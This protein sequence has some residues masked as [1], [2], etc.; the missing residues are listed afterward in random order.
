MGQSTLIYR[1]SGRDG[2]EAE[3][4]TDRGRELWVVG[5]SNDEGPSAQGSGILTRNKA[6]V[7]NTWAFATHEFLYRRSRAED[8]RTSHQKAAHRHASLA[9]GIADLVDHLGTEVRTGW[10]SACFRFSSHTRV[11]GRRLAP[12]AFVCEACGSPTTPC[13]A[14]R[15]IHMANRGTGKAGTPRYCA[16]HCHQVYGFEK[17][18]QRLRSIADFDEWAT[19]ESR[20]LRAATRVSVVS[21]AMAALA[22]PM[23]FAAA[24]VIGGALGGSVLGGGLSGAAATSHGLAMLGFGSVAAGGL[25]MQGGLTVVVVTGTALGGVLGAATSTAYV[26][27]DKSFRIEQLRDGRGASVLLASGFLTEGSDGWGDWQRMINERYPD[28]PV[29]RIHWG[30]KELSAFGVLAGIGLGKA[31]GAKA[32]AAAAGRASRRAAGKVPYAA[33]LFLAHDLA[34]NPWSI[35]KNRAEMTGAI[36]GDVIART[37]G[38]SYILVGHSLGARVMVTAAHALGTMPGSPRI[39]DVHL[40]GAAI[41]AKGDR[42]A[43][44]KSVSGQ[45]WNYRSRND[46]VLKYIYRNVQLGQHAAGLVGLQTTFPNIKNRDVS[47]VVGTHSGYFDGLHLE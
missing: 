42:G 44:H 10:C 46:A 6:L 13:V 21:G 36:L 33:P 40:L 43:L 3:L 1:P 19:F 14:P 25:G 18:D 32:L 39:E 8:K 26:C 20:N 4:T 34:T 37:P 15:C 41:S 5:S 2:F 12:S 7:T 38:E 35:A 29:Y 30:S 31:A 27:D 23:A 45:V 22:V 11:E 28:N 24:P 9:T 17:Q 16:E 47:R